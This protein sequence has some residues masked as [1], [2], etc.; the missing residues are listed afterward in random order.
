MN[1]QVKGQ[2]LQIKKVQR[3]EHGG[4]A[5]DKSEEGGSR[6]RILDKSGAK[7]LSKMQAKKTPE[8]LKKHKKILNKTEAV[9][10]SNIELNCGYKTEKI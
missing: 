2:V 5:A 7:T 3:D 10:P 1:H 8:Y 6:K 9:T 4:G